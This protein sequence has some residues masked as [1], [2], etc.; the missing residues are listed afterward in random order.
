MFR[1]RSGSGRAL[2]EKWLVGAQHALYHRSGTWFHL[3]ERFPGALFDANGYVLFDTQERFTNYP[4]VHIGKHVT[5]PGGISQLAD[6]VRIV[7]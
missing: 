5:V 1:E 6:Y 2:N 7:A 4:G 3:L